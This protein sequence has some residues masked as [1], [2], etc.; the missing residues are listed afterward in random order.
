[1][2][3]ANRYNI[4]HLHANNKY[5]HTNCIISQKFCDMIQTHAQIYTNLQILFTFFTNTLY[6]L[7]TLAC[8]I[9]N[10]TICNNEIA[11]QSDF[12]FNQQHP[13]QF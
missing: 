2:H 4:L 5:S 12:K 10:F 7:F 3:N 13:K 11:N 9:L 1:M 8:K 6:K